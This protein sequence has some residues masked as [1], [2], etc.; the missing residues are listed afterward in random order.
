MSIKNSNPEDGKSRAGD[1]YDITE[2]ASTRNHSS[3]ETEQAR[4]FESDDI[5][6]ETT[7]GPVSSPSGDS[8]AENKVSTSLD[9][10]AS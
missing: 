5:N 2:K 4:Q 8:W 9:D 7:Q 6:E 1:Y 3:S 10:E